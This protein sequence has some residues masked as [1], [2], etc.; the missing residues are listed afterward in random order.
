MSCGIYKITNTING[1]CYIGQSINIERRIKE[2]LRDFTKF[3]YAIY[4]AMRKYGV[5]NFT[6]DTIHECKREELDELEIEYIDKLRSYIRFENSNGYNETLGGKGLVGYY[7]TEA[8]LERMRKAKYKIKN[9]TNQ[10]KMAMRTNKLLSKLR[11]GK[12]RNLFIKSKAIPDG[13]GI[14]IYRENYEL[15]PYHKLYSAKDIDI[16]DD[17]LME[18]IERDIIEDHD[19]NETMQYF[20][21]I[22]LYDEYEGEWI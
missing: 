8:N 6:F 16:E 17:E 10:E 14:Y 2:H 20:I 11:R 19:G 1:K 4:V 13:D 22:G 15:E 3:D 7:L 5:D 9:M 12:G 21:D 18:M